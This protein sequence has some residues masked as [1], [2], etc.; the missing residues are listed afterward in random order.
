MIFN[1]ME[2][3][4]HSWTSFALQVCVSLTLLALLGLR[5]LG[6]S[7]FSS[8]F[9]HL[10]RL[11]LRYHSELITYWLLSRFVA[12]E[13]F[14]LNF[15]GHQT[16]A[17]SCFSHSTMFPWYYSRSDCDFQWSSYELFSR[18]WVSLDQH[19]LSST[20]RTLSSATIESVIREINSLHFFYFL[21]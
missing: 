19:W 11:P 5:L 3:F 12:W 14:P 16:I 15:I 1:L 13:L 17:F 21:L 2:D 7:G 9:L 8:F 18:L 20:G 4:Y 6:F 10:N